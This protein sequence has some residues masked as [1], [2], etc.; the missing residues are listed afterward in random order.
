M[1]RGFALSRAT[2]LEAQMMGPCLGLK[3]GAAVANFLQKAFE[4]QN[5]T[6]WLERIERQI[7]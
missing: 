3:A 4:T 7:K 2:G 6:S 5:E 1:I